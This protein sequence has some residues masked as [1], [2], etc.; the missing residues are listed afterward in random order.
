MIKGT[1]AGSVFIILKD[2]SPI[3]SIASTASQT[4]I[5][6]SPQLLYG[7]HS[8][9]IVCKS[10]EQQSKYTCYLLLSLHNFGHLE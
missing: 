1:C 9:A 2:K 7:T 10:N 6:T 5:L 4:V 3:K 8:L